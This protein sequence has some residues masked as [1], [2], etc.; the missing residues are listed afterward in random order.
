MYSIFKF[1]ENVVKFI[2]IKIRI[3]YWKMKYGKR[4]KIGKKFRF[5]KG[6]TI[7]IS[8]N[9]Y[10]EIGKN[11]AFNNYCSI[12]CHKIIKIGDNNMFGENVKFYDHNHVFYDKTKDIRY[13]YNE[14]EIIIGNNN[15]IASDVTFLSK[16]YVKDNNVIGTKV[17]VNEEYDSENIIKTES[18][19]IVDKIN[20]IGE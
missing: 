16:A 10:L 9:G 12:N 14:H 1:V 5:R 19:Y 2:K 7:N 15:W 3:L 11:N 20:Y 6:L 18:K 17:I 13:T 8:K 4:I